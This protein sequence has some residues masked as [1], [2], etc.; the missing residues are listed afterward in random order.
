MAWW[1]GHHRAR[2]RSDAEAYR[3]FYHTFGTDALSAQALGPDDAVALADR[4][5]Q[6]IIEGI[7]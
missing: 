2:G 4:I 1:A 3:R 7:D 5:N 6:R